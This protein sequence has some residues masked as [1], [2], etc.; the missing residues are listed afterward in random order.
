LEAE[1]SAYAE[2]GYAWTAD[3]E[4]NHTEGNPGYHVAD[5]DLHGDTEGDDLWTNLMMYDRTGQQEYL[6]RARA[7]ARYFKED[8]RNCVGDS[9]NNFCYD[10]GAFGADHLWGWGLI[11]WYEAM[12]DEAA[13]TELEALGG[14]VAGLWSEGSDYGCIPSGGCLWYGSR[15]MGRHL[16]FMT[17]LSEVSSDPR[18]VPLRDRMVETL[19]VSDQ[20]DEERGMYFSGS[21]S[22]DEQLGEG[23]YDA[24]A[25]ITSPFMVGVL[26][27]GMD[28]AYRVTGNEELRRRMVKMARFV[29]EHG[30]DPEYR[31]AGSRFGI[32]GG[33]T[34]H[35]YNS[36]GAVD[37][38]DP[39]YTTSLVNTLV[40]G[41][42][43]TCE[44]HFLDT[45]WEFFDRGNK[46]IHGEPIERA[47]EDGLIHHFVD[48]R[49][50]TASGNFYFAYNKGELQYTYLLFE[51][52]SL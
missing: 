32:V 17:R 45:A 38:W 13:L 5:P 35:N 46:G 31:Y 33:R 41:Y 26:A 27:E 24:G 12:G 22:T 28:H 36:G 21:W 40:R 8:Y 50:S 6:D 29:E 42:R 39:V 4:P 23:A 37:Y 52:V 20:W 19:L 11:A 16:L 47:A 30:L 44:Q 34:W 15:L 51:D 43:Y 25:R 49:F 10:M 48:S 18:W 3:A 9:S 2:Q 1:R 7:W 14:V